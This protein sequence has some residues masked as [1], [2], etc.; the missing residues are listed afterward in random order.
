[1][2][3]YVKEI[4]VKRM[5]ACQKALLQNH[6][7]TFIVEDAKEAC[8]FVNTMIQDGEQVCDGG[9]MTLI[10]TG[11]I[12]MLKQRDIKYHTH[13]DTT[14]SRA[15][16]DAES[17]MAFYADTFLT[18]ANAITLDGEIINVD[19]HGNRVSATI[20]GPKQVIIVAGYNK[21][22]KDEEEAKQRLRMLAAPANCVRLQRQTPC[23][24]LGECKDCKSDDRICSAY[25]KLNFDR[26]DRLR[27]ILIKEAFGY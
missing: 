1:M 21:I 5:E 14:M 9:S 26:E 12:D 2:D 23:R 11:I 8:D 13:G 16:S 15:E 4:M 22:V 20:F 7:K 25:V 6:I 24:I 18:S 3:T 17:R 19:G 10:D 27:M